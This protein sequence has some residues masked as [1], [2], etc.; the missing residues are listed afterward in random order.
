MSLR[1]S[2]RWAAVTIFT[3][4]Y[5]LIVFALL[6]WHWGSQG[7]AW[8]GGK[9]RESEEDTVEDSVTHGQI[10]FGSKVDLN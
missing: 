10:E 8:E 1:C 9:R 3:Y 5:T 6:P 7:W 4:L 2:S